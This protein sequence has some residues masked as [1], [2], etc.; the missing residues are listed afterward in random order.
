MR[1]ASL[2]ERAR[3]A[4]HVVP[5]SETA[6]DRCEGHHITIYMV[7]HHITL[8]TAIYMFVRS[9]R[10][11]KK[12]EYLASPCLSVRPHGTTLLPLD[13][14]SLNFTFNIFRKYVKIS[15]IEI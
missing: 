11:I 4:E 7:V 9:V 8:H 13:A 14:F 1:A 5:T 10:K 2:P 12:S 3:C 6:Y 15:F